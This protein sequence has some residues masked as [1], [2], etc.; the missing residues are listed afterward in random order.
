MITLRLQFL[1]V[2]V[3]QAYLHRTQ[4]TSMR[5]GHVPLQLWKTVMK[6]MEKLMKAQSLAAE[7]ILMGR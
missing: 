5:T 3:S 2:H 4:K 1:R 7:S 6:A